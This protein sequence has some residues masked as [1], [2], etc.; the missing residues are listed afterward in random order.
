MLRRISE[1]LIDIYPPQ[2]TPV[3][4]VPALLRAGDLQEGL[5]AELHRRTESIQGADVAPSLV[6]DDSSSKY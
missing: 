4:A 2:K 5:W 6:D 1:H 3:W